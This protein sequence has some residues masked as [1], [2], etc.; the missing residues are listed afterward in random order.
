MQQFLFQSC[1]FLL[2]E[3][4]ALLMLNFFDLLGQLLVN[5]GCRQE[6]P[7]LASADEDVTLC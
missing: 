1:L 6:L 5:E 3:G 7:F 4:S 2:L